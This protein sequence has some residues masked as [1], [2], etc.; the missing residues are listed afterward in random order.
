MVPP[1]QE[2]GGPWGPGSR[3]VVWPHL[4]QEGDLGTGWGRGPSPW[5]RGRDPV[6]RGRMY[7][8][9]GLER[10]GRKQDASLAVFRV[11]GEWFP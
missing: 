11:D 9:V 4:F 6:R 7:W 5:W 3:A 2:K 1:D 8:P 10:S